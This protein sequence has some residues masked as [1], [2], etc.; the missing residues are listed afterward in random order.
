MG[1]QEV[2]LASRSACLVSVCYTLAAALEMAEKALTCQKNGQVSAPGSPDPSQCH[3]IGKGTEAAVVGETATALFQIIDFRSQPCE[4]PVLSLECE[5][6]SEL[7]GTRT[8][9]SVERRGQSQ[10]EISYQP[11]IKGRHQLHIKVEGQHIRASP[12]SVSAK[13][14]VEKLGTPILTLG[15]VKEPW[16]VAINQQREVVVTEMNACQV[17]VFSASGEKLQSFGSRGSSQGQFKRSLGVAVDEE[18]NILIADN[19]NHRIQKFT[20]EGQ[21]LTAESTEGSGRL[22]FDQPRG[23]A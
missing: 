16:G 11:T 17:S 6:V 15:G 12:F 23:I 22:Q 1:R 5:L 3:A 18:G 20:P 10:Y 19:G 9:G 4:E 14:P 21:F 7:T 8:R 2:S 13:S